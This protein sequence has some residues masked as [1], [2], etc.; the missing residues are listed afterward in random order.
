MD[1]MTLLAMLVGGLFGLVVGADLMVRGAA[2]LA[3][4]WGI[5]PLVVGLTIVSIGTS[6]P[7]IA[8][9][10]GGAFKGETEIAIGNVVGS[11]IFNVLGVLGLSALIIPLAVSVQIIRQEVPVMI[12][13]SVL[14][15]ASTLDGRISTWDALL[16]LACAAGYIAFLVHQSRSSRDAENESLADVPMDSTW[17][18]HWAVRV[19]L[20]IVG[21]ILLVV[22]SNA[23]VSGATDIA[24]SFGVSDLV[25]G[26]TIVAIG[27][28]LPELATSAIAAWKGHGDLAIGNVV[29][30]N[31]FNIILCLGASGLAAGSAGLPIAEQVLRVDL[32]FMLA[33]AMSCMPIFLGR[34]MSRAVGAGFLV[35]YAVYTVY[36]VLSSRDPEGAQALGSMLLGYVLPLVVVGL[37]VMMIRALVR[38]PQPTA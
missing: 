22:G 15:I 34:T 14:L 12:G 27:T 21:L 30:S 8:V 17:D 3:L 37:I 23:L 28:S 7:E 36:L 4:S 25:I 9:S 19:G 13:V 38:G 24:K 35:T 29:G 31:I 6:A 20:V 11:N 2:K 10:V 16:F 5:S 33:V 18:R 32:W 26:L 1:T